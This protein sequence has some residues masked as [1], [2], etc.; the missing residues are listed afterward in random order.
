MPTP[1][2]SSALIH[3]GFKKITAN[4]WEKNNHIVEYD[5]A[6]WRLNLKKV[7]TLEEVHKAIISS[8]IRSGSPQPFVKKQKIK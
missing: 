4:S 6:I 2:S 1:I 8:T 7:H 3:I 5:G